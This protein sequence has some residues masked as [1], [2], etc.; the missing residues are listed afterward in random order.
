VDAMISDNVADLIA[1]F[2]D[3]PTAKASFATKYVNRHLLDLDPAGRTR[4]RF[5]LM[6]DQDARVLDVRTSRIEERIGAVDDFVEAGYE[7]H[8]NLSPVVLRDGWEEDWTALL[9]RLDDVLSPAAKAQAAA[10]VILLTHEQN[11]HEVNLGWHPKAEELLWRPELQQ[12]K[13]SQNG[14]L[15]VRYRTDVKRAAVDRLTALIASHAPWL[16]IRYA[17]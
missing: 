9:R 11:L 8:L 6:P 10:E 5:S 14:Q 1:T 13:R 17:F 2:R 16:D 12:P 7:V 3:L 4:V 15:N